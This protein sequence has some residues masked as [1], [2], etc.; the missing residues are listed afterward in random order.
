MYIAEGGPVKIAHQMGRHTVDAADFF[1]L[2]APSFQELGLVIW[3]ADRREGHVLF[4]NGN[5]AAVV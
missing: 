2:E 4:Q 1:D 5:L 3:K